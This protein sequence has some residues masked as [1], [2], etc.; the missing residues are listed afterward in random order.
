MEQLL[1]SKTDLAEVVKKL[2]KS[3]RKVLH[4]AFIAY[5]GTTPTNRKTANK[6]KRLKLVYIEP[7]THERGDNI[8]RKKV[9]LPVVSLT[10]QGEEAAKH[11]FTQVDLPI[12]KRA[13]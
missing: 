7:Y 8:W 6:L 9:T 2:T 1:A 5:D 3:E 4:S 10:P 12:P 11:A 13:N